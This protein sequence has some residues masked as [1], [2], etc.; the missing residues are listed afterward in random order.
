MSYRTNRH[1]CYDLEYH[2]VVVTKYRNPVIDGAFKERLLEITKTLFEENYSCFITEINTDKDH[3]HI[4]FDAPPQ[5]TLSTLVNSFKTV[6][7]RRLR[8]E[9]SEYLKQFYWEPVLWSRSYFICTVS[10]RSH[11]MVKQ[12][13]RN[14]GNKEKG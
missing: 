4:L 8:K 6:T 3:I 10:E 9:F 11:D 14:Q 7:S 12:Y 1:S 13:I 2:L 5:T